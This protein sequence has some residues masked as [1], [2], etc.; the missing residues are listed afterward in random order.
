MND[1]TICSGHDPNIET[2]A[3]NL[4]FRRSFCEHHVARVQELLATSAVEANCMARSE[5]VKSPHE[6]KLKLHFTLEQ[7]DSCIGDWQERLLRIEHC[8]GGLVQGRFALALT[9]SSSEGFMLGN[10]AASGA[11]SFAEVMRVRASAANLPTKHSHREEEICTRW[12]RTGRL[13]L[14]DA[15]HKRFGHER[16]N[17][18]RGKATT[19]TPAKSNLTRQAKGCGIGL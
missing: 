2:D 6:R 14:K 3:P 16:A 17:E 13:G 11:D 9:F 4:V 10:A 12:I 7:L 18:R 19:P 1:S 8:S 5:T 15:S